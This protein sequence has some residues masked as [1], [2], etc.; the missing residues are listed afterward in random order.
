MKAFAAAIALVAPALAGELA[1][2]P[3]QTIDGKETSLAAYRGKVLLLVN[4]ASK[5]GLT[6]QYTALEALHDRYQARGLVVLGF[7]C[8]DFGNQEPGS[9]EEIARF[10]K[11]SFDVSFPLMAKIHVK[12][13]DRHP[14][15][16]ALSGE[17]GAFP[18]EVSWNFGKF[19]I[20]KD[21]KPLARFEPAQKPDS[22][23]IT[24]AIEQ[25]LK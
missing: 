15:Y 22:P 21:G 12:G 9:A 8:N 14:L 2:I 6:A 10:C 18:G 11:T 13:P 17:G 23:E 24:A 25:A 1:D 19:L 3:F 5:C 20:G 16:T 7:P 4:T